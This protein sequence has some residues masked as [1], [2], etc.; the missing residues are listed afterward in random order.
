MGWIDGTLR[1]GK[2]TYQA[3]VIDEVG[4]LHGSSVIKLI[5]WEGQWRG[6]GAENVVYN[7]DRGVIKR[8]KIGVGL[9]KSVTKK[10]MD[11]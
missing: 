11:Y 8:T 3:K 2:Y 1:K 5:I 4:C 9:A 6:Q 10:F 7:Y